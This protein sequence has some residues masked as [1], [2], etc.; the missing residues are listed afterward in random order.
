M[1]IPQPKVKPTCCQVPVNHSQL[2]I[3]FLVTS[4]FWAESQ[5]PQAFEETPK[6]GCL[7]PHR[8]INRIQRAQELRCKIKKKKLKFC[9]TLTSKWNDTA[10]NYTCRLPTVEELAIYVT[11]LSLIKTQIFS[12]HITVGTDISKT[13]FTLITILSRY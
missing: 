5:W 4:I 13:S 9:F 12:Y 8:S 3:N 1:S 10:F 7:I 6:R 11:Y 2:P